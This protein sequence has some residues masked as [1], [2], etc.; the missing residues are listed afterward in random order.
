MSRW[1]ILF[2]ILF[3]PS[4]SEAQLMICTPQ[5]IQSVKPTPS[6]GFGDA[7]RLPGYQ[8]PAAVLFGDWRIGPIINGKN[9]SVGMPAAPTT[10]SDGGWVVNFPGPGGKVDYISLKNPPPLLGAKAISVNFEITGGGFTPY[11]YPDRQALFSVEFQRRGDNWSGSG[12]Y[13][14]YRWYGHPIMNLQ[15]GAGVLIVPLVLSSWTNVYGQNT[16]QAGFNLALTYLDNISITFGHSS[17]I[18]HGVYATQPSQFRMASM[19]IIR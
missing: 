10:L 9:Y 15:A 12:A 17:G 18:G 2:L 14:S 6:W 13:A 19:E 5:L 1:L 8:S 7:N 11:E 4:C 3:A 16:D